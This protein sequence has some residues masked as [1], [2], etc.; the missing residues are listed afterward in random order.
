MEIIKRYGYI[1]VTCPKCNS[2][3]KI[4]ADD[5][6]FDETGAM[7]FDDYFYKCVVCKK[8]VGLPVEQIPKSWFELFRK[9]LGM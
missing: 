7:Y 8:V 3:L 4:E 1:E 6:D 9:R 2:I 5:V